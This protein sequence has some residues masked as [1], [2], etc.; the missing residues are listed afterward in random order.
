MDQ[1]TTRKTV[2]FQHPFLLH[3]EDDTFEAGDYIVE[4]CEEMIEG[5]SFVAYRRVST[6]MIKPHLIHGEAMRQI[7]EVDPSDLENALKSDA[8]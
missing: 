3:S 6:M 8:K 5:L 4:T 7:F 2:T 1:K